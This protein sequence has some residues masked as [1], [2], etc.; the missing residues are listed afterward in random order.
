MNELKTFDQNITTFTANGREYRKAS[1]LSIDR[2][3]VKQKFDA[4][5]A[6]GG[7]FKQVFTSV[8]RAFKLLNERK[9]AD[10][11]VEL[12][13]LTEGLVNVDEGEIGA[14]RICTLFWNTP[15]EDIRYYNK[16]VMDRKIADWNAEG[17]D[18]AFFLKS[19]MLSITGFIE[20]YKE[21]ILNTLSPE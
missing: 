11:A 6:Y 21:R 18:A 13:R 19:A 8:N 3:K 15:D 16:E 1:S 2:L 17:I 12:Y 10:A 9:D 14:F 20:S 5:F 4:A 7:D